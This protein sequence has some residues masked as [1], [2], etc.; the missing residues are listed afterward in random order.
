[1]D[2]DDNCSITY[3]DGALKGTRVSITERTGKM[4][5]M[6]IMQYSAA[7]RINGLDLCCPINLSAT[8]EMFYICAV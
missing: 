1:M 8:M 3:S 4:W 6:P 2:K 5:G 7:V